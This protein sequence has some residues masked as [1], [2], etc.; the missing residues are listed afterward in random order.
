MGR[1]SKQRE[2]HEKSSE[3]SQHNCNEGT[4][5]RTRPFSYDEIMLRRKNKKL[6]END[7]TVKQGDTG[8]GNLTS[9][10]PADNAST[11]HEHERAYERSKDSS[12]GAQKH[13]SEE[14]GKRSSR[15][16]V[17]NTSTRTGSIHKREDKEI[18]ESDKLPKAER[19]KDINT[20]DKGRN[21]KQMHDRRKNEKSIDYYKNLNEKKHSGD[22]VGRDR[23]VGR[24]EQKF[25][26]ESKRKHQSGDDQKKGEKNATKKHNMGKGLGSEISDRKERKASLQ[27]HYEEAQHKRRRSRSREREGKH[28]RSISPSLRAHK[29]TSHHAKDHELSSHTLKDRS[30]RSHSNIEKSR[31]ASNGSGRYRKIHV[32]SSSGLGGYSPRKRRTE[33]DMKILS[34][35]HRSPGKRTA[36]WDLAPSGAGKIMSG[37]VS[38]DLHTSNQNTSSNVQEMISAVPKFFTT[39]NPLAAMAAN[40]LST[41]QKVSIDSVQ[42][43]EATRP[44]RRLYVENVPASASEKAI[45]KCLNNFLLSSGINH[46]RGTQPCISCIIHKEKGQAL[47]EFLTPEDASAALSFDGCTLSGSILKMRRPKDF[48]E[49][50]GEL[51]NSEAAVTVSDIVKDSPHKIFLGGI[52]KALSSEM[53]MEIASSF[54]P[55]KAYHFEINGD[56]NQPCAFVEYVDQSV[57]LKACASLNGMKLGGQVITAVQAV[58]NASSLEN[59]GDQPFY[60]IPEL[61]RPLLEK[62]TQVLKLKNL[63]NMEGFSSLSDAE[64][65]DVLEDVR[66]ECARFGTVKSVHVV[67]DLNSIFTDGG[68]NEVNDYMEHSGDRQKSKTEEKNMERETVEE[69][70]D[71][72]SRRIAG[73]EFQSDPEPVEEADKHMEDNNIND[74]KPA[75]NLMDEEYCKQ[76][77]LEGNVGIEDI[78]HKRIGAEACQIGQFDTCSASVDHLDGNV[79]VVDP[80]FGSVSLSVSQV[81]PNPP[82]T[83]KQDSV[84]HDDKIAD[85]LQTEPLSVGKKSTAED[86]NL[87]EVNGKSLVTD[88]QSAGSLKVESNAIEK[89]DNK[90]AS[91]G[92]HDKVPDNTQTEASTVGRK[93]EDSD[94]EV[95]GKL[96]ENLAVSAG[97]IEVESDAIEKDNYKE[98]ESYLQHIFEPGC[99]FVEYRRTESSC[100]AAHCLQGRSFDDRIVTVEYVDPEIYHQK[101]P[102]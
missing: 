24:S 102:K 15:N 86:L 1:S 60:G 29:R 73:I 18:C 77:E 27:S 54:G 78:A 41:K 69:Y 67:K 36:K 70:S 95:N 11:I 16:G 33:I 28:K 85:N 68:T 79:T 47:V 75:I 5:A 40:Y 22:L 94:S 59:I 32:S 61:A 50:T 101:F 74:D 82:S 43:T 72:K 84:G 90:D 55:L 31:F 81:V 87:E 52:S 63:F 42:L 100:M 62:P 66:L 76:G 99:V 9:I 88:A 12:P 8:A 80:F 53:L 71:E 10:C 44:M 39:S 34:P 35:T 21:E 25:E 19:R 46:V 48:V 4:A 26:K 57:S 97:S 56:L 64:V 98:K 23:R 17:E 30:G 93:A 91:V 3:L 58:P 89:D 20:A 45:M 14:F 37:S 38:S 13:L 2:K 49:V 83:L 6:C 92:H 96:L 7:E 65:E 51:E